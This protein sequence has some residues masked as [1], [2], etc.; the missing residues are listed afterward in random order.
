MAR[1]EHAG[2]ILG[3][4]INIGTW[5]LGDDPGAGG[6]DELGLNQNWYQIYTSLT[7]IDNELD[8]VTA[9][10]STLNGVT[11]D[12]GTNTSDI[13]SISSALNNI[14]TH[15]IHT[16][17][18]TAA[19]TATED[20][21]IPISGFSP[22]VSSPYLLGLENTKIQIKYK[23]SSGIFEDTWIDGT[24]LFSFYTTTT[25]SDSATHIHLVNDMG[26]TAPID[27]IKISLVEANAFA[28]VHAWTNTSTFSDSDDI[29]IALSGL[30]PAIGTPYTGDMQVQ[31]KFRPSSGLNQDRWIDY[32]SSVSYY[33]SATASDS[34]T[35]IHLVNDSG[36]DIIAERLRMIIVK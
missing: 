23:P 15:Q 11:G 33:I 19:V 14:E 22:A 3:N 5:D 8:S 16:W 7:S 28:S 18:N 34:A 9:D 32:L 36:A 1:T 27:S 2:S 35:H 10:I 4:T 29:A 30:S 6:Y 17:S 21:A 20:V 13:S 26:S 25:A 31:V 24:G 12:I